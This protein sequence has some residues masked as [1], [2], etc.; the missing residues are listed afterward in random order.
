MND[1]KK[2]GSSEILKD[3]AEKDEDQPGEIRPSKQPS[4]KQSSDADVDSSERI[5]S[6]G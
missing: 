2:A 5:N 1:D 3:A 6:D 4:E